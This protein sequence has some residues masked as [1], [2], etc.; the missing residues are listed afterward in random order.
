MLLTAW[1]VELLAAGERYSLP[2]G[3]THTSYVACPA[4][5]GGDAR[6]GGSGANTPS[7]RLARRTVAAS[8]MI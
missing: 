5:S 4:A 3:Q 7:G 8:K 6:P 2:L 1:Q